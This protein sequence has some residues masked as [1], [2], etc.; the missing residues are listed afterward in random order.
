MTRTHRLFLDG[1]ITS[2]GFGQ[3]YKPAEERL[4]QLRSEHARLEGALA[5]LRVQKVSA[6][7]VV[8]DARGM[9][10]R[11]PKMTGPEKRMITE[12]MVERITIGKGEIDIKYTY[13]AA[14]KD[15]CNSHQGLGALL[16]IAQCG[17]QAIR[18]T[19]PAKARRSKSVPKVPSSLGDIIRLHRMS[20][21]W[22]MIEL[23]AK[24][25]VT[26][27][28]LRDWEYDQSR[29]P[30]DLLHLICEWL[31]VPERLFV[32]CRSAVVES[33]VFGQN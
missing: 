19:I 20:K 16:G 30:Y 1:E 18:P 29:P 4:N 27:Q 2:Q 5:H 26:L 11:W 32:K 28:T 13:D 14:S 8:S 22:S 33:A 25:G 6:D 7:E 3:F 31:A 9:Y 17:F 23:A 12:T 21:G 24:A 10:E 15:L